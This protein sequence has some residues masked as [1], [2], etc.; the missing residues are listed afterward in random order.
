MTKTITRTIRSKA[1]ADSL[2]SFIGNTSEYPYTVKI[3]KGEEKRSSQ[4]NRLQ[5][6]WFNDATTQGDLTASEYRAY[7]KLMFGCKILY[8][9]DEEFREAYNR[10]L[11]GLTYEQQ[12]ACMVPPLDLPV[13][14]RMSVKQKSQYLDMMWQHFRGLGFILTD[15]SMLGIDNWKEA[16]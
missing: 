3:T 11:R 9:Q 15:P 2:V 16:Q 14:S 6:Q 1:D 7:C 5:H 10:V 13:T 12:L 8:E 4:Q